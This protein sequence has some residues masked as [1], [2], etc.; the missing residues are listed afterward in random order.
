MEAAQV[1]ATHTQSKIFNYPDG[2]I[3]LKCKIVDC[4]E[5]FD[6]YIIYAVHRQVL[7]RVSSYFFQLFEDGF[8]A[9]E[10]ARP[11]DMRVIPLLSMDENPGIIMMLLG[12]AYNKP[13]HYVHV[14][15]KTHWKTDMALWRAAIKYD[16]AALKAVAQAGIL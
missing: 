14:N 12:V 6:S 13:H 7:G 9:T 2:D 1:A 15:Y 8:E 11:S 16:V 5:D 4:G 3:G 10:E